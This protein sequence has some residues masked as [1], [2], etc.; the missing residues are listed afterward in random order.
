MPPLTRGL[1]QY[2]RNWKYLDVFYYGIGL[3]Y[4]FSGDYHEA[5]EYFK[6]AIRFKSQDPKYHINLGSA[7]AN[8]GQFE[9]ARK[10]WK[11]AL[12]IDPTNT[13][14]IKNLE[15]LKG[16]L[17]QAKERQREAQTP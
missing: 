3:T 7:Y 12:D 16:V 15:K 14:A 9:L 10:E 8:L 11:Y 13:E 1:N 5:A 2:P 4:A 6:T 17:D